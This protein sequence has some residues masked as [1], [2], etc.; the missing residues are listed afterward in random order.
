MLVNS[1]GSALDGPV[2]SAVGVATLLR[3][4]R[5]Q[6]PVVS[7]EYA[8]K[9]LVLWTANGSRILWGQ[10]HDNEEEPSADLKC[11]RLVSLLNQGE[12]G[13]VP[14]EIDLRRVSGATSRTLVATA[15]G[16]K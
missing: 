16:E 4:H 9:D 2:E 15:D 6:I 10:P 14:V 7:L 11:G 3:F 8:G 13:R 5:R 12:R 1:R